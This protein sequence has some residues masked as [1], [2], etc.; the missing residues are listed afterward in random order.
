[1]YNLKPYQ[2]PGLSK[3]GFTAQQFGYVT[4]KH[5]GL[6]IFTRYSTIYQS[7]PEPLLIVIRYGRSGND[8]LHLRAVYL[9]CLFTLVVRHQ[10]QPPHPS[11]ATCNARVT[12]YVHRLKRVVRNGVPISEW[13][14]RLKCL[15]S[16]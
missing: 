3:S 1:M 12:A 5:A 10:M 7:I 8:Y 2:G 9:A 15:R 11:S 4:N 6:F 16:E 13:P 14:L